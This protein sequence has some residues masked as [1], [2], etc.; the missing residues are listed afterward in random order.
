MNLYADELIHDIRTGEVNPTYLPR[1][2]S[3]GLTAGLRADPARA[4]ELES[5]LRRSGRLLPMEAWRNLRALSCWKGGTMPL[6]LAKL[7]DYYGDCH[8]RDFGYM[9]SEG[10]GSTPLVNAGS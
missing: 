8:I 5:I 10:R 4:A 7:P 2:A 3:P 1:G 9:A 6:Y